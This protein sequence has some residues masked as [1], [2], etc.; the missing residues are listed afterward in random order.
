[1]Y[2]DNLGEV[3]GRKVAISTVLIGGMVASV[4]LGGVLSAFGDEFFLDGK[5]G[6]DYK[7]VAQR[8]AALG[9]AIGAVIAAGMM[10]A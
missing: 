2:P 8:N 9:G 1:M 7:K 10:A 6:R 4:A 5:K 3:T